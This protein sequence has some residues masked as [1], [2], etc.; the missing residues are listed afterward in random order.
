MS[1]F[2]GIADIAPCLLYPQKRTLELSRGMSALCQKRTLC[3]A[4]IEPVPNA[5]AVPGNVDYG[6][7]DDTGRDG[8]QVRYEIE[9]D[10]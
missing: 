5:L 8:D 9:V 6:V 10:A 3:S 4:A 2:G 1:A 7:D